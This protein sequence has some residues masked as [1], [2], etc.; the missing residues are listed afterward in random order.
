MKTA[1]LERFCYS[2]AATFGELVTPEGQCFA[3]VER[4]WLNNQTDISCIPVGEYLCRP[5]FYNAAGYDAIKVLDVTG[6]T[7]ILMHVGNFARNSNGC[8][9][10]NTRHG[11]MNQEWCGLASKDAFSLL[12]AEL[13]NTHFK[14][15]I[16]NKVGGEL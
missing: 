1:T 7:D 2:P 10:I 15:I 8:I 9:L 5:A 12:M 4:P 16:K 13:G 6:R 3:T 11:A 14:L